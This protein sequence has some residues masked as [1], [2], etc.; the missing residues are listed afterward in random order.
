[1]QIRAGRAGLG[2]EDANLIQCDKEQTCI[3]GQLSNVLYF[4]LEIGVNVV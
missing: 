1:M 3:H 2:Q 4:L